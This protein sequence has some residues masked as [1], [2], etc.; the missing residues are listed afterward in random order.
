MG[1]E[2]EIANAR[3]MIVL[4][5]NIYVAVAGRVFDGLANGNVV[6]FV[7]AAV[8]VRARDHRRFSR[9]LGASLALSMIGYVVNP[10]FV[11]LLPGFLSSFAAALVVLGLSLAHLAVFVPSSNVFTARGRSGGG[12]ATS[13]TTTTASTRRR[14]ITSAL[15]NPIYYIYAEDA[16]RLPALALLLHNAAQGL[17][18]TAIVVHAVLNFNFM[19]RETR[20]L[21]GIEKAVPSAYLMV[22]LYGIPQLQ[23]MWKREGS[24][25][26]DTADAKAGSNNSSQATSRNT[27]RPSTRD[28]VS[29][30]VCMLAQLV[31]LP[32]FLALSADDGGAV[33]V[34]VA[35]A[36]V[37]LAAPS[38]VKGYAVSILD[39]KTSALGA[40]AL[41]ESLGSLISPLLFFGFGLW[42]WQNA[43][44]IIVPSFVGASMLCLIASYL[45]AR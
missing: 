27:R 19:D 4:L 43:I 25:A 24:I 12:D 23:R 18:F 17:L 42:V 30:V 8:Y 15:F 34:L 16:I 31:S 33:Y 28:F 35:V 22:V 32:W 5:N 21:F 13:T 26:D 11:A 38:F 6:Q 37:G 45:M 14:R 44:V 2:K 20:I 36:S 9:L 1:G 39:A 29:S 40:L 7:L 3:P 10:V 41:T